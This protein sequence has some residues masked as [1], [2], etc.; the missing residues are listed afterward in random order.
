MELL[1]SGNHSLMTTG[2]HQA[3]I[4]RP[5]VTRISLPFC[6]GEPEKN[7]ICPCHYNGID[8][9]LQRAGSEEVAGTVRMFIGLLTGM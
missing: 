3:S 7:A 1:I 2:V 6:K 9:A 5:N 8:A 4:K